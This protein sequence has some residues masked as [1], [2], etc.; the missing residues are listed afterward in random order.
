MVCISISYF[1]VCLYSSLIICLMFPLYMHNLS[2]V[3]FCN[4]SLFQT[5]ITQI[6]HA[7]GA[8]GVVSQECKT[9]VA[10]YGKTIIEMLLAQVH[11]VLCHK[12]LLFYVL[13]M[14]L[15]SKFSMLYDSCGNYSAIFVS[16]SSFTIFYLKN[17]QLVTFAFSGCIS[18]AEPQKICSQVG[19][20]FFD[21]TRDTRS[22]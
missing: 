2:F 18:Q 12:F 1:S 3:T 8:T 4:T 19:L 15:Y 16:L 14:Y 20:C 9:V 5:V 6:N 11:I 17:N 21:G 7:I 13:T 22:G 10:Q